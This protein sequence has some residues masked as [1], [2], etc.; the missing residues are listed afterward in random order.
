[1]ILD[2]GI[3]DVGE[4]YFGDVSFIDLLFIFEDYFVGLD[5]DDLFVFELVLADTAD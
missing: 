3:G 4:D 2:Y 1:M 5:G